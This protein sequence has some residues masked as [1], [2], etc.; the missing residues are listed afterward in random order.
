MEQEST[1]CVNWSQY[2]LYRSENSCI[3][4]HWLNVSLVALTSELDFFFAIQYKSNTPAMLTF[5]VSSPC[6]F[7]TG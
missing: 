7:Q 5:P 3:H 4:L 6:L 1:H 2:L